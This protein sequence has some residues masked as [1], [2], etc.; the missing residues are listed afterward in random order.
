MR[1][2]TLLGLLVFIV[3]SF[4]FCNNVKK[5]SSPIDKKCSNRFLSNVEKGI[6]EHG[7]TSNLDCIIAENIFEYLQNK[8][9][10]PESYAPVSFYSF[11]TISSER[12]KELIDKLQGIEN[13]DESDN[14][15][16]SLLE[17]LDDIEENPEADSIL[18]E[19]SNI[20]PI[21]YSII[22]S[23]RAKNSYGALELEEYVFYLDT[24]LRVKEMK[25]NPF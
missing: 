12:E 24:L 20:K 13:S 15:N 6:F 1:K 18:N 16:K 17:Q 14:D 23:F 3:T 5:E 21:G 22:H 19:I 11:R 2:I 4:Q 7:D 8:L 9:K 25:V 10:D